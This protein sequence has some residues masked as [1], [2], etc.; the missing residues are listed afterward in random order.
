MVYYY[1]NCLSNC[2]KSIK[3][4]P[5]YCLLILDCDYPTKVGY[6]LGTPTANTYNSTVSVNSCD[7]GYTGNPSLAE[8]TCEEN[9]TWSE[10]SGC[11]IVGT[12]AMINYA[13]FR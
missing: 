2:S 3:S 9:G 11:T 8:L 13:I 10:V 1:S 5:D 4:V 7:T 6:N 12:L